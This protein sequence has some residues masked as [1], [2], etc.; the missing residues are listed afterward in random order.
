MQDVVN[1]MLNPEELLFQDD[2]NY[3]DLIQ[4][5]TLKDN[6]SVTMLYYGNDYQPLWQLNIIYQR[7]SFNLELGVNGLMSDIQ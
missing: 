1:T 6:G 4:Q 7:Y 3:I 5:W 2:E